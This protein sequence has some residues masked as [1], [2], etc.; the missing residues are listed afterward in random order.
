M[1]R[2]MS[3]G[4][5]RVAIGVCLLAA[6][7][8]LIGLYGDPIYWLLVLLAWPCVVACMVLAERPGPGLILYGA[9]AVTL[10]GLFAWSQLGPGLHPPPTEWVVPFAIA[11]TLIAL[12]G[13]V[14][15][16]M[17]SGADL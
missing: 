5:W 16:T 2:D 15:P 9:L 11:G 17:P 12:T 4:R 3:W 13:A 7:F 10:F 8:V 6:I 1:I 14:L